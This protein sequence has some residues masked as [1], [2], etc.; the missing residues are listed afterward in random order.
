MLAVLVGRSDGTV[1]GILAIVL[2]LVFTVLFPPYAICYVSVLY[3]GSGGDIVTVPAGGGIGMGIPPAPPA[4]PSYGGQTTFGTPPQ[5]SMPPAAP[6]SADAWKAAADPLASA[7]PPPPLAAAGQAPATG[8]PPAAGPATADDATA[9]TQAPPASDAAAAAPDT[10]EAP[11]P[12][13][14]PGT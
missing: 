1:G 6:A 5:Y 8:A 2:F 11:D 4:P 12:P 9:V 14:P 13:A 3:V 10:P 7:P